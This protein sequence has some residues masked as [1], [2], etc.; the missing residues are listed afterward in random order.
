MPQNPATAADTTFSADS[1]LMSVDGYASYCMA[2][3]TDQFNFSL[4]L[5]DEDNQVDGIVSNISIPCQKEVSWSIPVILTKIEPV[6]AP[7]MAHTYMPPPEPPPKAWLLTKLNKLCWSTASIFGCATPFQKSQMFASQ[8]FTWP[9]SSKFYPVFE[10]SI[11]G[12]KR[13]KSAT[14]NAPEINVHDNS[15]GSNLF[16]LNLIDGKGP[17]RLV[18]PTNH[19][20]PRRIVNHIDCKGLSC[21]AK[22]IDCNGL[23]RHVSPTNQ[24]GPSCLANLINHNDLSSASLITAMTQQPLQPS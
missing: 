17:S 5:I 8:E 10:S 22:P 19:N 7:S 13:V 3:R 15:N 18:D 11:M 21:I 4:K 16:Y 14:V 20:G 1:Y 23:S 2:N 12:P 9:P 24:N 6:M